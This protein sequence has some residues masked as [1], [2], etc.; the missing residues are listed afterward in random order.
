MQTCIKNVL[1]KTDLL[2]E[3]YH[4]VIYS[5]ASRWSS[6]TPPVISFGVCKTVSL[7]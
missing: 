3:C 4:N 1:C 6:G 5:T 2:R 7:H